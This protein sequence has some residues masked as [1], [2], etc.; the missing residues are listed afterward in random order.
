MWAY[1]KVVNVSNGCSMYESNSRDWAMTVVFDIL[2][3]TRG[4]D[5]VTEVVSG[6]SEQSEVSIN[7][8]YK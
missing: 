8:G 4:S 1:L 2:Q 7:K 3:N 5:L 6:V